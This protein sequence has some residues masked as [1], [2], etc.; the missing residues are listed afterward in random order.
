MKRI[1]SHTH[2]FPNALIEAL[3]R[4]PDIP[5]IEVVDGTRRIRYG[6]QAHYPLLPQMTD[7]EAKLAEMKHS[8]VERGMLSVNIPGVDGLG[9][10]AP[11]VARAVNDEL[12]GLAAENGARLGWLGALPLD[13]PESAADELQRIARIGASGAMIYSNVAG[14]PLDIDAD[15]PLFEAASD[16][17]LPILLHPT[18]PLSAPS[19]DDF[20]L[21]S[22]LGFLFDTSTATLRL[23][24]SGLFDRHPDL[25]LIVA[26]AGSL[27]PYI[28]GRID[29]Q[30]AAWPG[31]R[32]ALTVAPSEHLRRLYVDSVSLW[33]PA[34]RISIDFLGANRVL[35]GSDHP[36][37]PLPGSVETLG[38]V[39][40][41]D[42]D[43]A[44]VEGGN[45]E[46]V[47]GDG[48]P[49]G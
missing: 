30:S 38:R 33:P 16:A 19:V 2:H 20:D 27:I 6:R 46:R 36:F 45:A 18:Y 25:R 4:R 1:D 5:R 48:A 28:V 47:F 15:G 11:A 21:V 29:F 9:S 34:L 3:E 31:G 17:D 22:I 41:S 40:L 12:A 42:S 10:E 24:F 39:E 43:R 8:G 49:R 23:I 26:H 7:L 14:R 13:E 35:F 32:G 37:W 44:L